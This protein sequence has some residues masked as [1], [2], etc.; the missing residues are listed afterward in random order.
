[1]S[2]KTRHKEQS[3][4]FQEWWHSLILPETIG[5]IALI[6]T[7][8]GIIIFKPGVPTNIAFAKQESPTPKAAVVYETK[9]NIIP[10]LETTQAYTVELSYPKTT[11]NVGE[12]MPI[13][14][15]VIS[16][17]NAI[18]PPFKFSFSARI[19]TVSYF[20]EQKMSG[21]NSESV[22]FTPNKVGNYYFQCVVFK[23]MSDGT[24]K[25]YKDDFYID[26]VDVSPTTEPTQ[27]PTATP[28]VAVTPTPTP[29]ETISPTATPTTSP[30]ATETPT[31]TATPMPSNTPT[32][33]ATATP[34]ATLT[35]TPT[36]TA[37]N[38]PTATPLPTPTATQ[39]APPPHVVYIPVLLKN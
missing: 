5:Y 29:T 24:I 19:G 26:V 38:T 11:M 8:L 16:E 30:T 32:E 34:T 35:P 22:N 23:T 14:C 20:F 13:T 12:T 27:T 39:T 4:H 1:M 17:N 2:V 15:S 31:H 37:T 36:A 10:T 6:L 28:T 7:A 33:T 18:T 9:Q 25:A 3:H 21:N